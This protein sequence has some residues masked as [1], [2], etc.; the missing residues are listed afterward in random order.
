MPDNVVSSANVGSAN[1]GTP[2]PAPA[3]DRN[4]A[5]NELASLVA[6]P[7]SGV[8][9]GLGQS[10]ILAPQQI[11]PE[12]GA[13]VGSVSPVEKNQQT[14]GEVTP[15]MSYD[16]LLKF[17]A[18]KVEPKKEDGEIEE[19]EILKTDPAEIVAMKKGVNKRFTQEMQTQAKI[20]EGLQR[21]LDQYKQMHHGLTQQ[22]GEM[23][24]MLQAFQMMPQGIPPMQGQMPGQ[25]GIPGE[26]NYMDAPIGD[27]SQV[28][29]PAIAAQLKEIEANNQR[30]NAHFEQQR[31][32]QD[33]ARARQYYRE[34]TQNDPIL[35][36][37]SEYLEGATIAAAVANRQSL[38][39]AV[40]FMRDA[41]NATLG[42]SPDKIKSFIENS[43]QKELIFRT[44]LEMA[45]EGYKNSLNAQNVVPMA[46]T[47]AAPAISSVRQ[48]GPVKKKIHDVVDE[49]IAMMKALTG[50]GQ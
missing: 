10:A 13:G 14:P 44:V 40:G 21:E 3:I 33:I 28:V 41:L 47:E 4:A 36:S 48:P 37:G 39:V 17:Y 1:Q 6:N 9:M 42:T 11:V 19:I 43:P 25:M 50:V 15:T 45:G 2:G 22:I 31:Q 46:S 8:G 38:D 30:I 32:M 16:D 7:D 29:H 5:A 20:R 12:I 49:S 34:L 24:G 23:K 26:Q 18:P 27:P 35:S